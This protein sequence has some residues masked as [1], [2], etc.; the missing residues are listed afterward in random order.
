MKL[1]TVALILLAFALVWFFARGIDL[2]LVWDSIRRARVDYT[3]LALVFVALT[4]LT[5]SVR[6]QYLL[7]PIGP[8]RFRTT[9]RT[10]I[11]GF[12][13]LTLLPAR[14]GDALRP[15]LLA[16]HEHLSPAATFATVIAERVLDLMAVVILLVIFLWGYTE[17][18]MPAESLAAVKAATA[19]AGAITVTGLMAMWGLATH[20]ERAGRIMAMAVRHLPAPVADKVVHG[21]R[22]FSSGFAAA[23]S[24]RHMVMAMVWS[25]PI[26]LA[27]AAESWLV[28]RAFDMQMSFG[29]SFLLQAFL[30]LGVAVPTPAGVGTYHAAYIFVLTTFFGASRNEATAGALVLHAVSFL[31]I[32]LFGLLFMWQDRLSVGSLRSLAAEAKAKEMPSDE[33]SI[34]RESGR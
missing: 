30:I 24:P 16:R 11:I 31:P 21:V 1:R 4:Y 20:P 9:F 2:R 10:T 25:M 7:L 28:T 6:W 12:A 17:P 18:S 3:A 34:L 8:V 32:V 22:V 26:W 19:I 33:M 23:R 14:V 13:V 15:Y 27:I 29:G 5:R